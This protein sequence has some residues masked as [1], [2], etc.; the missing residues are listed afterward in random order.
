[1]YTPGSTTCDADN[2]VTISGE[3]TF[4]LNPTTGVVTYVALANATSGTK[5]SITYRVTDI[6]GQTDTETLTPI[7]PPR[8]TATADTSTGDWDVNQT[9]SPLTNDRPGDASAP[10]VT[11]TLKLCGSSETAPNCTKTSLTVAGE[12]TY[13]V[14]A[15]GTVTFDPEVSFTDRTATAVPYRI[16]DSLGQVAHS[17]ITP[18]VGAAPVP[19]A[20]NDIS[21]GAWDTNQTITPLSNDTANAKIPLVA[22]TVKLCGLTPSVQTPP[23]CT[24]TSLTIDGQGTYTVNADGTVTFDP[25][26]TLTTTVATPPRYQVADTLG[27]VV[28]A[29]ITPT[30]A[31]PPPPIASPG[32][33]CRRDRDLQF[34]FWNE[35]A[36]T[37]RH[38]RA[39]PHDFKCLHNCAFHNHMRS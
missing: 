26:S 11:S 18:T 9:I 3:G 19:V 2:V 20:V 13:T 7:V 33:V 29:T 16:E 38:G 27:Q 36:C 6:V 31:A 10:L 32:T 37:E 5:T 1:L 14:N 30:V 35:W 34:D 17:T 24:Q 4:T 25:V 21:S 8:P 12:G 28:N 15:N 39:R 22:S 23:N